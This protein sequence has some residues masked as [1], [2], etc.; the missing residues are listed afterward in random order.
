MASHA[1]HAALWQATLVAIA[2]SAVA[3]NER[4]G[5]IVVA[6]RPVSTMGRVIPLQ[7]RGGRHQPD[8]VVSFPSNGGVDGISRTGWSHV[9]TAALPMAYYARRMGGLLCN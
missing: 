2:M 1:L 4:G 7:W 8:G 9:G 5:V 6:L 3:C